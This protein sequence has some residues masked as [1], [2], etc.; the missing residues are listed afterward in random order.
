MKGLKPVRIGKGIEFVCMGNNNR[1]V[2]AKIVADD[3]VNRIG[4]DIP[5]YSSGV[6]VKEFFEVGPMPR[7]ID[8]LKSMGIEGAPVELTY[9]F[10]E[11]EGKM[12]DEALKIRG[13]APIENH[14]HQQT[15]PRDDI[16]LMLIVADNEKRILLEKFPGAKAQTLAEY[17]GNAYKE[18][19]SVGTQNWLTTVEPHLRYLDNLIKIMPK[20]MEKYVCAFNH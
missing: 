15:Y 8:A 16:D 2:M 20:V 4:A 13:Y 19:T 3:Y 14:K 6:L 17:T 7:I 9:K 5:I 11:M 18:M 10:I 12:R 1:S